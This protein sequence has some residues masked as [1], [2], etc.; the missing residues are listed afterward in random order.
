LAIQI[1]NEVTVAWGQ[2][3][4]DPFIMEAAELFW[5]R[6][7]CASRAF[8]C[9]I[10]GE[11]PRSRGLGSSVTVRL[12]LLY[13]LNHLCGHPLDTDALFALCTELEGHP[14]N[15]AASAF[16]GFT[17]CRPDG[18]HAR[19]EVGEELSLA[20]LIPEMECST[21]DARKAV[22]ESFSRADAVW[23][24][25]H[26][27]FLAAAFAGR[28]YQ[29]LQDAFSDRWHQPYRGRFLPFLDP[30]IHAGRAAGALGG[31]LSGSGSTVACLVLGDA[32][33]AEKVAHAME[34]A[35]GIPA[36]IRIARA[37]NEGAVILG[38]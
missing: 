8:H 28:N 6:S 7:A 14:D 21:L 1:H 24:L 16:G 36:K 15:A 4:E 3:E 12:G 27:A 30:V 10:Q 20:L 33:E 38:V 17:I 35:C 13:G 2:T 23:N 19:Y 32:A 25:G 18:K 34:A 29:S 5:Q 31:W 22:P 9:R 37:D 26:T 11:V